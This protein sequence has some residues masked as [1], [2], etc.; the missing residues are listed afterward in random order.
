[1]LLW[2][3][4][5]EKCFRCVLHEYYC[6]CLRAKQVSFEPI[7]LVWKKA[8]NAPATVTIVRGPRA[9]SLQLPSTESIIGWTIVNVKLLLTGFSLFVED[10][11]PTFSNGRGTPGHWRQPTASLVQGMAVW[12]LATEATPLAQ[13]EGLVTVSALRCPHHQVSGCVCV[14]LDY[15]SNVDACVWVSVCL[16]CGVCLCMPSVFACACVR[17]HTIPRPT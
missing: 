11:W 6:L 9:W 4:N 17:T 15:A 16:E 1:M 5:R 8:C 14:V 3:S 2:N 12:C 7:S 10:Q 13:Q